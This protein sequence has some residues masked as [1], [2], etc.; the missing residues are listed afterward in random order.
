MQKKNLS[1]FVLIEYDKI[2]FGVGGIDENEKFNMRFLETIHNTGINRQGIIDYNSLVEIFKKKIYSIEKKINFIFK[3]AV[4][5]LTNSESSLINLCGFKKLNGSQLKKEN[6]TYILNSLKSKVVETEKNKSIVHIFNT[7]FFLD[8]KNI[9]NL[10]IGLFGDFYSQEL[11]FFLLDKNYYKNLKNVLSQCNL[12]IKKVISKSFVDGVSLIEKNSKLETFFKIE[13]DLNNTQVIFFE[14]S[15]LRYIQNFS[16]GL[17]IINKDISKI[18]SLD[19]NIIKDILLNSNFSIQSLEQDYV[20]Q[21]FFKNNNYRKI[22]KKLISQI[23]EARIKE[24]AEILVIKNTNV[25]FLLK[26]KA[27]IFLQVNDKSHEMCFKNVYINCFSKNK[28]FDI[29][30][31]YS[32]TIETLFKNANEIVQFGWKKEAVP[33]VHEKRSMIAKIFDIFFKD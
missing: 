25:S 17:N 1:L 23:A 11:A 9:H 15:S 20:E 32:H 14:N 26:K 16:F 19:E 8:K 4:L 29:K 33:V 12:N 28:Y 6:I 13:I 21:K 7:N 2:T 10:P 5:V 18:T 30:L 31:I 27:P 3:E 24:L 22:K